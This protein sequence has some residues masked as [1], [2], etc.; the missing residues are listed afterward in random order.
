[1]DILNFISGIGLFFDNIKRLG[2]YVEY[3]AA[4]DKIGAPV[5]HDF[6]VGLILLVVALGALFLI[7]VMWRGIK[8]EIA[9]R[10]HQKRLANMDEVAA[11]EEMATV[12]WRGDDTHEGLD[13]TQEELAAKIREAKKETQSTSSDYPALKDTSISI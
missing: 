13:L 12:R 8:A 4:G 5:C 6:W 10:A 7:P 2:V 9:W 3:C 1:M 11:P